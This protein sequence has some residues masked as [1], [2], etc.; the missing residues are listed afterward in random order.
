MYNNQKYKVLN[1]SANL[2]LLTQWASVEKCMSI[3]KTVRE[4]FS[5]HL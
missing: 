4:S 3:M 5:I 1:Y 2:M